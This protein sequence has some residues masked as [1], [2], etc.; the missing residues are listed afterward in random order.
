MNELKQCIEK[1]L[2]A[3]RTINLKTFKKFALYFF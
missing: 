3:K 2:P 1:F